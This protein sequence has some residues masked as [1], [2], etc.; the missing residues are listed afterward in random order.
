MI[1]KFKINQRFIKLDLTLWNKYHHQ[2]IMSLK[3]MKIIF[4]FD[5]PFNVSC[6]NQIDKWEIIQFLQALWHIIIAVFIKGT[7]FHIEF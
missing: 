2:K 5:L 7:L 4:S 1:Y 6:R 3:I